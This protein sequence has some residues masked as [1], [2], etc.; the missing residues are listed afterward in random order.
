[1]T[2]TVTAIQKVAVAAAVMIGLALLTG[3]PV[4]VLTVIKK[5]PKPACFVSIA[6]VVFALLSSK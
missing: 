1:M 4:L 5:L 3:I 2:D 6:P